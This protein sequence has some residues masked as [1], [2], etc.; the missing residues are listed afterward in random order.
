[1]SRSLRGIAIVIILQ[2]IKL[3]NCPIIV[4]LYA[5]PVNAFSTWSRFVPLTNFITNFSFSAFL[6]AIGSKGTFAPGVHLSPT[7]FLISFHDAFSIFLA[8]EF[9]RGSLSYT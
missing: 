4:P 5:L 8:F 6:A 1:M 3:H 7:I 2:Q 9:V